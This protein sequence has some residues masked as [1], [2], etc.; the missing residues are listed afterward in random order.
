MSPQEARKQFTKIIGSMDHSRRSHDH[1]T[2]FLEL[3]YC[4]IKKTTLPPGADADALEERYMATV[5]RS[6]AN[7]VRKMPEL[8]GLTCVQM[9]DGGQD[10]L[11][12]IASE[13]EVLNP[14]GG[15]FFTPY[16][17]S[18]L[19]AEMTLI[20]VATVIE[21]QGFVTMQE[22]ASGSGCMV[23]AAA[24]VME[25]QAL[26]IVT[27]LYVVATDISDLAFKMTYLQ[28]SARGVPA[29]VIRGN[30]L[31][32]EVFETAQTPA[33]FQFMEKNHEGFQAWRSGSAQASAEPPK[34]SLAQVI[35]RPAPIKP[36]QLSLF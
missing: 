1:F 9:A 12:T 30:T 26:D 16:D 10:F 8:L 23:V 35:Q 18:R 32:L 15:Q 22:P 5:G 25:R 29:T 34:P 6:K 2:N 36:G 3:A 20:D 33:F 11:G 21:Q 24:D 19:N 14:R 31:S 7:D 28:L 4:S 13:M 17:I 27:T